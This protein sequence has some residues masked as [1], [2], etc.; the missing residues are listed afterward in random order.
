M[1]SAVVA[2]GGN[3]ILRKGQEATVE[4]QM[5][6]L[7]STC[8]SLAKMVGAGYDIVLVHG[9][10]PQVGNIV[11]QNELS[12]QEVP[13]MPLDVCVAESQGQVGF[14]LQQAMGEALR[15]AGIARSV[16]CVL[17]RTLVDADD[18][19]FRSPSKPIGP[20]YSEEEARSLRSRRRWSIAEDKGRG[21]WRR[22]VPSPKP[23]SI[24][25]A[26]AIKRLASSGDSVVI[27]GGGGGVP[28]VR[29]KQQ[30]FGVEAVVDKDL[31]AATLARCMQEDL[32][33]LLTDVDAAYLRYGQAD[34]EMLGEVD[35]GRMRDHLREGHFAP[36]SMGPKVEAGIDF[37]SAA[38]RRAVITSPELLDTALAS[39]AGTRI[40]P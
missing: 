5:N 13:S 19:A 18:P 34:Q 14:M 3:A 38:G 26:R 15:R 2:I 7:R 1:T 16:L 22:V 24:I 40:V 29:R 37:V 27:A 12:R 10:G 11:L 8:A 23:L 39:M 36:G 17:T 35:V 4:N 31:A 30:L 32:L 28:V 21:G 6:N 25:E 33:I 20:Y 9:N